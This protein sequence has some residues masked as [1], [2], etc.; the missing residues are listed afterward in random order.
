MYVPLIGLAIMVAWGVPDLLQSFPR[1]RFV[2]RTA[3]VFA[4][5]ACFVFTWMQVGHWRNGVTLFEHNFAVCPHPR[6]EHMLGSALLRTGQIDSAK[7]HFES[8]LRSRP[9]DA[10]T[11]NLLGVAFQLQGRLDEALTQFRRSVELDPNVARSQYNYANLLAER[12]ELEAAV[13]AYRASLAIEP[14]P[15]THNNLGAVLLKQQKYQ[16]AAEEFAAALAISPVYH[17]ARTNLTRLLAEHPHL[18]TPRPAESLGISNDP[19][20][21][22]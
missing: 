6:A 7:T 21:R 13:V 22:F 4:V 11:L 8:V 3:A 12:S 1:R 16:E 20:G 15:K 9:D 2:V 18:K 14:L 17:G 19:T 10:A 5:T